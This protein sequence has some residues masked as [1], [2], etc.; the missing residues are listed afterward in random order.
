[1]KTLTA[2]LAAHIAGNATSMATC[3]KLTRTDGLVF[4]FT[5]HNSDLPIGGVT[6]KT[7][8]GAVM[9][10]IDSKAGL[11]VD[12]AE[13]T[14]FFA[15][16]GITEEDIRSGDWDHAA[17]R[18]FRVNW[19]DLTMGEEKLLKGRLG[20]ITTHSHMRVELRGM[21]AALNANIGRLATPACP[22]SLGDADCAVVLT[23]YTA[24]GE[25]TAFTD[26][27]EFATDLATSSVRL[28]PSA[29][30]VPSHDYF[31]GGVLT[32]LTGAN[33]GRRMEVKS[34]AADGT[35]ELHL[36]MYSTIAAADTFSIHAGCGKTREADCR[37]RF[38]NVIRF[39]GFDL[40][41]GQ[42]VLRKA[43]GQ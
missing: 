33:S 34:Y 31:R 35:I 42:D 32:W 7:A 10:A 9:T 8:P 40:L 18:L 41:P 25:V 16:A 23:D 38:D 2:G 1:M 5:N 26:P 28:S 19:A 15:S 6:Y 36:P 4:G 37:D 3:L 24:A 27:R 21:A 17:F 11:Q 12:N 13:M 39:G 43:G 14:S 20:E 30:G 22:Y 29:T